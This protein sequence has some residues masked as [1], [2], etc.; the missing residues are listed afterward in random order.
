MIKSVVDLSAKH[1]NTGIAVNDLSSRD[2]ELSVRKYFVQE[3]DG[4]NLAIGNATDVVNQNL[5][6]FK[7]LNGLNHWN[8]LIR[9]EVTLIGRVLGWSGQNFQFYNEIRY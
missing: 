2:D 4:S 9:E 5:A 6:L 1:L 7:L 3:T 8:I